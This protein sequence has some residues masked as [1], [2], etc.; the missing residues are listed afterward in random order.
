M[1]KLK[2]I[3]KETIEEAVK[4]SKS[5]AGVLSKLGI[6]P[7]SGSSNK[8]I[9]NLIKRLNLNISHFTGKL[10]SKGLETKLVTNI[11]DYFSGK[12]KITSHK[13]RLRLLREKIF[14]HECSICKNTEWLNNKIPLQLDHING[15]HYDNSFLN[16]RMLCPICHSLTL[17]F[18]GK[19]KKYKHNLNIRKFLNKRNENMKRLNQLPKPKNISLQDYLD[20]KYP[21][22][23]NPLKKKLINANVLKH[24]CNSCKLQTW[25]EKPI[26]IQ[27]HHIN[28]NPYDNSLVNLE[29]LCPN[30]HSLTE[31]WTGKNNNNSITKL[32]IDNI[33]SEI[34]IE[35]IKYK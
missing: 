8:S 18:N 28:G 5:Y 16:L 6:N 25:N 11:E 30:C 35:L 3:P 1:S 29:L 21:I 9:K 7:E 15:N 14:S 24:Q 2:H 33:Q 12:V 19:N 23:S 27:L 10:W 26:P 31:N 13:L 20:N 32:W 17:N 22:H 4:T 34:D